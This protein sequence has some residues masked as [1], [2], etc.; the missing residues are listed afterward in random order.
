MSLESKIQSL[1]GMKP[2]MKLAVMKPAVMKPEMKLAVMKPAVMK[3]AVHNFYFPA[4]IS[5]KLHGKLDPTPTKININKTTSSLFNIIPLIIG[6]IIFI[7]ALILFF[8]NKSQI[9]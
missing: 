9:P 5:D 8:K 6:S 2:E 3:P 7:I 4:T 1:T